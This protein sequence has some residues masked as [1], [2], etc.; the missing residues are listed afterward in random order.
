MEKYI[1]FRSS[2]NR[3]EWSEEKGKWLVTIITDGLEHVEESDFLITATG[4]FSQLK[5]PDY[6]GISDYEGHLRHSSNWDPEF[7]PTGKS[8]AVI[9]NGASGIQVLPQLQK[10][11]KHIHH[12]ARSPTWIAGTFGVEAFTGRE[13]RDPVPSDPEEYL[14][15]RKGLEAKFFNRI[16][17]IVKGGDKNKA[18]R[19]HFERLMAD[20]LGD[21]TDLLDQIKPDFSP[22]CRRL[23]PGPGY[24]E[25]LTQPNVSYIP[26]K[27]ERFTKTGIKTVD[28]TQHDVDAIICSTG[29]DIS[30]N[31]AFPIIKDG[32]D[33]QEAWRP[34]GSI[35]FPDTYLGLAAPGFPNLFFVLG[36]NSAGVTGSLPYAVENQLTYIA[37]ALRKANSQG[38]RSITP[39][40][41]A[42]NDFRGVCESFFPDTVFSEQC[43]SWYNGGIPG[44][45]IH[46]IWPGSALH[47]TIVQRDVRWEDFE[48]KY[49]TQTGNRFAWLGNG[50]TK[51][52]V[53][54][55][56][57]GETVIDFTPHLKKEALEG[58]VD[59]KGY[60]ESWYE[61]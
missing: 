55:D 6:P 43:S 33:L 10:V 12:Y 56:K 37:K 41:A 7:D 46:G 59:L 32:F 44:G 27:I 57:L 52:E 20:R 3:A 8:I 34:T 25:A 31:V 24:L 40:Q 26:T 19:E 18:A 47:N 48:Y 61:I 42:T 28:G 1:R 23:T 14:K 15:Y 50:W 39:T 21:R 35:G 16:G 5:L 13:V 53:I 58:K 54:A 22:S 9:G 2:V 45:R 49:R 4:V 29:A 60:L 17:N 51:K 36:A 30:F 11:A 38:I